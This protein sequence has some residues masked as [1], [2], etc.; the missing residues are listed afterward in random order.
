M[1]THKGRCVNV[2]VVH[3]VCTEILSCILDVTVYSVHCDVMKMQCTHCERSESV[4]REQ[5]TL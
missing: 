3:G 5:T 4:M 1:G 2:V